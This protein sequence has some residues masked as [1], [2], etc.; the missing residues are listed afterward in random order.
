MG[1][2]K[3]VITICSWRS[4]RRFRIASPLQGLLILLNI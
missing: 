1:V 3:E 4:V 2:I